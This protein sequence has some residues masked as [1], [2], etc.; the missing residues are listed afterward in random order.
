MTD[1]ATNPLMDIQGIPPFPDIETEHVQP[2][3]TALCEQ[4]ENGLEELE[5]SF[6]ASWDSVVTNVDDF[7]RPLTRAW[8]LVGHFMSVLNSDELREAHQAVQPIVI[9][10]QMK[11]AQSKA[12]Y[13]AAKALKESDQWESFS[14][15]QHRIIEDIL[16]EAELAGIALEGE[17]KERFNQIIQELSELSTRFNNQL[18]DATKAW[19]LVI[20]DKDDMAGLPESAFAMAAQSAKSA[21]HEDATPENGPWRITLDIP[22]FLPFMQHSQKREL[23]EQVYRAYSTKASSGENDNSPLLD[24]I[25]TLRNEQAKL[26]GY[27]SFAEVSLASKMAPSVESVEDLSEKVRAAAEP[28]A[29]QDLEDLRELAKSGIPGAPEDGDVRHWDMAFL[30]ERLREQRYD[31]SEEV[32][33]QYFPLNRVLDGMF[34]LAGKLFDIEIQ[35]ADGEAPIWHEDVQ[36]FKILENG[37]PIAFFHLDPYSRPENK[38]GG[39]WMNFCVGRREK[40]DGTVDLPVAYLVCNQSPPVGDRPSLMRFGEVKTMFHEFGH[41][42]QHMLTRVG[43]ERAAGINNVEWD[44]VELASQFMEYWLDQKD[45]VVGMSEHWETGEKLPDDLWD[46]I[47]AARNFQ[48][49]TGIL[50]QIAFGLTDLELYH[51]YTPGGDETPFDVY[52]RI[53]EK[54]LVFQPLPEDRFLCSFQHIFPGGYAAGYYSYLWARVLAADAFAA[55]DEVGLDNEEAVKETGRRYRETVLGLGGG[56]HPMDCSPIWACSDPMNEPIVKRI[57][58]VDVRPLRQLLLRPHQTVDE[59]QHPEDFQPEAFHAGLF[60]EDVLSGVA[61][62]FREDVP[63]DALDSRDAWRLRAMAVDDALRGRGLGRLLATAGI[64]YARAEGGTHMWCSARAWVLPFYESLGFVVTGEPFEI[65]HIG[66][67]RYMLLAL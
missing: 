22:S 19:E 28:N 42:V 26:L 7:R 17:Q 14:E 34:E 35:S 25:I 5:N 41:G 44:A 60:V 31:F 66:T 9:Q 59:T 45:V 18:L 23:R 40:A 39:A 11:L 1:V 6:T 38:R 37:E 2:A 33:R 3:I 48:S 20:T 4:A 52:R 13:E 29:L 56:R 49:G 30:A 62:F 24:Q 63:W 27:N 54:T 46:K 67:H 53:A 50:R 55:F 58:A 65:E 51:R 64:D 61:S 8:M 32:V 10:T 36:Y 15:A 16:L 57:G 43:Y 21:G 12:H 47:Y